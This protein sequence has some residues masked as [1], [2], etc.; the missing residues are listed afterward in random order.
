MGDVELKIFLLLLL[1]PP[2]PSLAVNEHDEQD[3]SGNQ[4][5]TSHIAEDQE[6]RGAAG[7][8][9]VAVGELKRRHEAGV[10]DVDHQDQPLW[11]RPCYVIKRD[12]EGTRK[13][14]GLYDRLRGEHVG[15]CWR[16][17]HAL[18]RVKVR[19]VGLQDIGV[20]GVRKGDSVF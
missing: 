4:Q 5:P 2:R 6:D 11:L 20:V 17:V 1:L 19:L 9:G 7:F 12:P 3:G 8:E 16:V 10:G 18:I 13:H 15:V 14:V